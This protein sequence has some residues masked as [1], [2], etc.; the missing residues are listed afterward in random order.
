MAELVFKYL[1]IKDDIHKKFKKDDIIGTS[2][3]PIIKEH[4]MSAMSCIDDNRLHWFGYDILLDKTFGDYKIFNNKVM[5][6]CSSCTS[7]RAA[8]KDIRYPIIYFKNHRHWPPAENW[9]DCDPINL[10]PFLIWN[11]WGYGPT[12]VPREEDNHYK[13]LIVLS[14]S[15]VKKVVNK[16]A[17]HRATKNGRDPLTNKILDFDCIDI[18]DQYLALNQNDEELLLDIPIN[19]M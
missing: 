12:I 6:N 13:N 2:L 3:F 9:D 11:G 14:Y 1:L 4:G 17:Y 19:F 15:T 18:I 5:I 10:A 16:Y 7:V 8:A